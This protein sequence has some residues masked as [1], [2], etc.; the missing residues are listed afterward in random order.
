M[1]DVAGIDIR[2]T[3]DRLAE[4]L[5]PD[6]GDDA[7]LVGIHT[8]GVWVARELHNRLGARCDLAELDVSFHRDDYNQRGMHEGVQP[9]NFTADVEGRH[10]ILTDDVFH[11]GRTARAALNEL[12]DFGRPARV[13]LVVLVDRGGRELPLRP[14]LVGAEVA[15]KGRQQVKLRGPQ[16]LRLVVST[17]PARERLGS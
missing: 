4:E 9:S 14:D 10:V 7:V 12:F 5:A 8:G 13:T 11:T 17:A 2:A 16:P 1:T 15:L 3:L 6:L